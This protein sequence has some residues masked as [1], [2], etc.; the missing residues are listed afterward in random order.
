MP[1]DELPPWGRWYWRLV[2]WSSEKYGPSP[3]RLAAAQAKRDA[4]FK[5]V[6]KEFQAIEERF[7]DRRLTLEKED[8]EY[9]KERK[10]YERAKKRFEAIR[11]KHEQPSFHKAAHFLGLDLEVHEVVLAAS[12]VA[13]LVLF[14][15]LVGSIAAVLALRIPVLAWAMF[16]LP[17]VF[18]APVAVFAF[19]ANYA[20]ILANRVRVMALGRSPEAIN[21]MAMSMRLNPSINRAISFAGDNADEPI[22]S[23]LKK[24]L[25]DVYMR[26]HSSIEEAFLAFAF[27]WGYWNDDFK[28]SLYAIRASSLE[29]TDE[30]LQRSLDKANDIILGGTTRKIEEFVATLSAPTTVLFA[31]GI[32][33][34]MVIGATLPML[35]LGSF[36]L[37]FST[38]ALGAE[39]PA[40]QPPNTALIV[41]MMDV[42]FPF[43]ALAYAYHILGKR[44]GTSTPPDV[45]SPLTDRQRKGIL[46]TALILGSALVALGIVSL[47]TLPDPLPSQPTALQAA[48]RLVG[49]LPIVWGVG[50]AVAM[51]AS[52]T[53]AAQKRR[54]DE[55]L[56]MEN[57]FPDALFQLG[58]RIAEGNPPERAFRMTADS[59]RGTKIAELF[60]RISFQLQLTRSTLEEALFG[61]G[62]VIAELPSRTIRASMKAVVEV[63]KKDPV[64]AGQTIVGI[65]NYL[66]DMK[67]IEHNIRTQLATSV[68]SIRAT[69]VLFAPIVMGVTAALYVL[70]S[71]TFG[72]LGGGARVEM[73]PTS[74]FILI[75]G[76]Y[77]LFTVM[78]VVYFV[79]GIQHGEDWIERKFAM[80]QSIPVA[81]L[82]FSLATIGGQMGIAGV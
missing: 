18:V 2:K 32:L 16:I 77:L 34:P 21:Y 82:V 69:G 36:D 7:E 10:R 43:T 23:G 62:G 68:E 12:T 63:S 33:L 52:A 46:T 53:S 60:E 19:L 59:M 57:E 56:E 25:W 9:I 27:E 70:L 11:R 44:P 50:L 76:L 54:R 38:A 6:E 45:K 73:I 31:L 30:G 4:K 65:S 13:I 75:V 17:V 39:Q 5:T 72:G 61:P 20:E 37:S 42:V 74:V 40:P 22:A 49:P 26:K 15:A 58:S 28:R 64:T 8:P 80:G 55:I 48:Q 51:Y 29:K 79:A 1:E 81:L 3:E 78:I 41:V 35:S 14:F 24:V 71:E 67:R 47:L 66:K